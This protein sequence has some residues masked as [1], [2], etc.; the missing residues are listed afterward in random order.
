MA[1]G[2]AKRRVEWDVC[3]PSSLWSHLANIH[4]VFQADVI[5]KEY[6]KSCPGRVLG[7][8]QSADGKFQCPVPGCVG[9]AE[10]KWGMYR[11]FRDR[12]LLGRVSMQLGKGTYPKHALYGMQ[13]NLI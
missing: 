7:A 5:N 9:E 2:W 1:A 3:G 12:D 6:L 8:S 10:T 4:G 13:T 11:H